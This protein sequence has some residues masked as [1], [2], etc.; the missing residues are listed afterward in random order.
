MARHT[1]RQCKYCGDFHDV[2]NWPANHMDPA[3]QRSHLPAPRIDRD[4]IDDLWHP[5]DGKHYDSKSAFRRVTK[6]SGG[7]EVGN[8]VQRDT[9]SMDTVTKDEVQ[10]A[11][12]MVSQGYKPGVHGTGSEGWS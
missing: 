7:E 2:S 9:R 6:Q 1:Y 5:H 11:A 12:A 3:P 10:K 8:E 4:G